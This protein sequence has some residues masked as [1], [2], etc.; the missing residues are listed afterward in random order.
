MLSRFRG[1]TGLII[2]V[3]ILNICMTDL[4]VDLGLQAVRVMM[5]FS[6]TT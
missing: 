6:I 4:G 2:H 1:L 3:V 5:I